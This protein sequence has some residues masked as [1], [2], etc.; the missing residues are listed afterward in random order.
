[1]D[2]VSTSLPGQAHLQTHLPCSAFSPPLQSPCISQTRP[3]QS[4]L[5]WVALWH[6]W[7]SAS[8]HA[9]PA[10][11]ALSQMCLMVRLWQLWADTSRIHQPWG[12]SGLRPKTRNSS[13]KDSRSRAAP[14]KSSS[15]GGSSGDGISISI[16][17][18]QVG[19]RDAEGKPTGLELFQGK[20]LAVPLPQH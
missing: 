14:W 17:V 10:P 3:A 6:W 7:V 15:R 18:T 13:S 8:S 5:A 9:E 11:L 2:P 12:R 4:R 1:M 19:C 16:L 20:H